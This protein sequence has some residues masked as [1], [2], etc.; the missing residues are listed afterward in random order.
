[1]K[2]SKIM[3]APVVTVKMDDNLHRVHEIFQK[4]KFHHVLV[5]DG[6][7]LLG[8]ISDRDLLKAVSARIG[9][10]SADARDMA[11]FQKKVYQIMTRDLITINQNHTVLQAVRLFNRHPIS[12]L[13]VVDDNDHWVGIVSWR[14]IFKQIEQ[15]T[16]G[17]LIPADPTKI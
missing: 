12:C 15:R 1:M 14:D 3:S 7:T 4:H 2:V 10:S 17:K 11:S 16:D 6:K 5:V 13:P 9:S 8:V